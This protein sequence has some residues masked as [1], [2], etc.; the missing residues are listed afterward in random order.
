MSKQYTFDS[1][2]IFESTLTST[3]RLGKLSY[4]RWPDDL[5]ES[6]QGHVALQHVLE[7]S[8][9]GP[10]PLAAILVQGVGRV[11]G[12]VRVVRHPHVYFVTDTLVVVQNG[13]PHTLCQYLYNVQA[14][15]AR[16]RKMDFLKINW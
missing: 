13:S 8:L 16:F 5:E 12:W 9:W 11:T 4:R 10:V 2:D 1:P 15:L 7:E 6:H 3:V 14:F